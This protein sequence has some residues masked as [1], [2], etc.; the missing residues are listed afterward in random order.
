M[1]SVDKEEQCCEKW[2]SAMMLTKVLEV[3]VIFASFKQLMCAWWRDF[4]FDEKL[5]C[6]NT[7][8]GDVINVRELMTGMHVIYT[9]S[10][11]QLLIHQGRGF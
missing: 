7:L 2:I 5:L 4:I 8:F 1:R 6:V 3:R 11:N 9:E 10:G